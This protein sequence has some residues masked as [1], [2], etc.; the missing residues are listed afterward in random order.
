MNLKEILTTPTPRFEAD[1]K[2]ASAEQAL[3]ILV[4]AYG[5]VL[6]GKG[7]DT[8]STPMT[9][10]FIQSARM[11]AEWMHTRPTPGLLICG[12][13]GNGKTTMVEALTNL[14]A[15][16]CNKLMTNVTALH[17]ADLYRNADTDGINALKDTLMLSID[18]LGTEA[19]GVKSYGNEVSPVT[20]IIYHR[21]AKRMFTVITTNMAAFQIRDRYGDRIADR[22][23]EMMTVVPFMDK[24]YRGAAPSTRQ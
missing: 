2:A 18:D 5:G 1:I 10:K 21:Y 3:Y 11:V 7:V 23:R 20:D 24:S 16:R 15:V 9:E 4:R 8:S 17:I 14:Y 12:E 13:V 22:F 19:A 6:R